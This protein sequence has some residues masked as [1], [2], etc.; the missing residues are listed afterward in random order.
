MNCRQAEAH[1]SVVCLECR[2]EAF[3]GQMNLTGNYKH[4]TQKTEDGYHML[5]CCLMNHPIKSRGDSFWSTQLAVTG[6]QPLSD[7]VALADV[8]RKVVAKDLQQL[9]LQLLS[10][11]TK[12]PK[13]QAITVSFS[14]LHFW[15]APGVT[16]ARFVSLQSGVIQLQRTRHL[17][18]P[19][20]HFIQSAFALADELKY[21]R[22]CKSERTSIERCLP[23]FEMK[24]N[25][26]KARALYWCTSTRPSLAVNSCFSG[27]QRSWEVGQIFLGSIYTC[28][29]Q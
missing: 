18:N 6:H 8:K 1:N 27:R 29:G 21:W 4:F 13:K 3:W 12:F 7:T 23:S 25:E 26:V 2:F 9:Q 28:T 24:W 11:N 10:V 5:D 16:I 14:N 22:H 20:G 17:W 15:P 19:W